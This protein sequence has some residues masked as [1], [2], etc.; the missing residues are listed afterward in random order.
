MALTKQKSWLK[1]SQE[2]PLGKHLVDNAELHRTSYHPLEGTRSGSSDSKGSWMLHWEV[3]DL[4]SSMTT[5]SLENIYFS[6]AQ[7]DQS[8]MVQMWRAAKKGRFGKFVGLLLQLM[9]PMIR[10]FR[11]E[12]FRI[13]WLQKQEELEEHAKQILSFYQDSHCGYWQRCSVRRSEGFCKTWIWNSMQVH[14][15]ERNLC[16]FSYIFKALVKA[17]RALEVPVWT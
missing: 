11:G 6:R 12:S 9:S 7:S 4:F 13:S 16:S 10:C 2:S 8:D 5:D 3:L 17:N 1:K 15:K 14:T